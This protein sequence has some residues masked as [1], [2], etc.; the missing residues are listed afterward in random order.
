MTKAAL[1]KISVLGFS[2]L[3]TGAV[4]GV[5]NL[6]SIAIFNAKL[7]FFLLSGAL[8]FLVPISLI[9]AEFAHA[10]PNDTGV[11]HWVKKAFGSHWGMVTI[12]LQWI[13]T[14]VWF[15]TCLSTIAGT[16]AYLIN[17]NLTHHPIYLVT[18][19]LSVFWLMTWLNL[20]GIHM[21]TKLASIG[22]FLGVGIPFALVIGLSVIWV[23]MGKPNHFNSTS[24]AFFP[25]FFKASSWTALTA[26]ITAFLGMEL[27][28]VHLNEIQN[29][30]RLFSKALLLSLFF[31]LFTLGF[32]A[33]GVAVV[34]PQDKISLVSGSVQAIDYFLSEYHLQYLTTF[35]T[36]LL[37]CGSLGAMVNWL[38]SPVKGLLQAVH[39][40]FLPEVF[41]KKNRAGLPYYL[42]I[43]Q[44]IVISIT[45][46]AFFIMP[47]V[48][49]SYWLLLALST[50]LYVMMYVI[51]LVSALKLAKILYQKNRTIII[52]GAKMGLTLTALIGLTGSVIALIVGFFK[53][54]TV[55]VGSTWHY[56]IMFCG[57]LIMMLLPLSG[58][59]IFK[60]K[61]L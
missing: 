8:C 11:Y 49:G 54:D 12:W 15:P 45:S 1:Q 27:A 22:T 31:I 19:S 56:E 38:I 18:V 60:A 46:C 21:S 43:V 6:P 40:G 41:A 9:A 37:L 24:H 4:D 23:L 58:F 35:F 48:N 28:T 17:P 26:V 51:M 7:V 53:P 32:G 61:S 55:N 33:S 14:M 44:A 47:S 25:S 3:I 5:G 29:G 50:E 39:D 30:A 59:F 10:Y 52:P 34:L 16:A 2:L 42:Y 57:G 36:L 20:K 13:N